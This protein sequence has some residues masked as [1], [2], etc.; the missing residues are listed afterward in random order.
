MESRLE[1]LIEQ[2]HSVTD[3]SIAVGFGVSGP[4]QVSAP[5]NQNSQAG[6]LL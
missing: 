6:V 5:P 3:K 1:G 2:L 4:A